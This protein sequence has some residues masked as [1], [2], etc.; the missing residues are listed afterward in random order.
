MSPNT[1]TVKR[2]P[3]AFARTEHAEILSCLTDDGEWL[4]PGMF[5]LTG[6]EAFDKEIG[7]THLS[8]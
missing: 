8:Q 6:K 3:D 7:I 4:L 1:L 5:H 2:Y